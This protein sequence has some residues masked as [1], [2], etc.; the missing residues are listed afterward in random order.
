MPI[1]AKQ[2][3][4]ERR[5]IP[6]PPAQFPSSPSSSDVCV[7]FNLFNL[8]TGLLKWSYRV[9]SPSSLLFLMPNIFT[10]STSGRKGYLTRMLRTS[11]ARSG[12][13]TTTIH[14]EAILNRNRSPCACRY[15]RRISLRP[16]IFPLP[17]KKK[18]FNRWSLLKLGLL[19][20]A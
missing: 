17:V 5:L 19:G 6:L 15:A 18:N 4:G 1:W 2:C 11:F 10:I 9:P 16:P 3:V 20:D 13:D 8:Y 14:R 7:L 12:F